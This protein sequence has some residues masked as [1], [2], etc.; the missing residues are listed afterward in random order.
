[1]EQR[2]VYEVTGY[3]E[4][5][6][7]EVRFADDLAG[8]AEA[9]A[10][11][12][13]GDP[14][15]DRARQSAAELCEELDEETELP[16]RVEFEIGGIEVRKICAW[17]T[18][19]PTFN[20]TG[21]SAAFDCPVKCRVGRLVEPE[22]GLNMSLKRESETSWEMV[23]AC[24]ERNQYDD[25][26][27][28]KDGLEIGYCGEIP[29]TELD[30]ARAIATK[31]SVLAIF[32]EQLAAAENAG[33]ETTGLCTVRDAVALMFENKSD[34]MEM[35]Y[36]QGGKEWNIELRILRAVDEDTDK[37]PNDG[38]QWPAAKEG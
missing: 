5:D 29:W 6:L 33:A 23:T 14:H 15:T 22:K 18:P 4:T 17:L 21:K 32:D 12:M 20:R 36:R 2:I 26:T 16:W 7:P 19:N 28:T 24:G 1:M 37:T 27:A 3:G 38:V 25:V 34:V 30:E 11:L 35:Y 31:K 9:V 10:A 13:C 8:V